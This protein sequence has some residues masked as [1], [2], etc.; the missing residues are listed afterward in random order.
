[1]ILYILISVIYC[2]TFIA[3]MNTRDTED[4]RY[5]K[6]GDWKFGAIMLCLLGT[7]AWPLVISFIIIYKIAFKIL[8]KNKQT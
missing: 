2:A 5:F 8:N 3:F 7:I 1:M 4:K 6:Y